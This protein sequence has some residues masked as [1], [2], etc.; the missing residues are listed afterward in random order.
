MTFYSKTFIDLGSPCSVSNGFIF[1]NDGINISVL[2]EL[3]TAQLKQEI[4]W[5]K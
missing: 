2:L 1:K 4:F 5:N 3:E